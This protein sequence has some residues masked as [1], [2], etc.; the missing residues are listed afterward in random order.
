MSDP[1]IEDLLNQ[2]AELENKIIEAEET[3]DAIKNDKIDALVVSTS[4]GEKVY[5]LESAERPYR[6]FLE[7]MNEGAVT[8]SS[9]GIVLF[10]N[11]SFSDII[12]I[13]LEHILG[14]QIQKWVFSEDTEALS[15]FLEKKNDNI[16]EEIRFVR[17]NGSAI[18]LYLSLRK[19]NIDNTEPVLCVVATDLTDKKKSEEILAAEQLARSILEQAGEAIVVCD[20]SLR[21]I[22]AS[23]AAESLAGEPVLYKTFDSVFPLFKSKNNSYPLKK[24]LEKIDGSREE[25]ILIKKNSQ[26][27][28]LILNI[29]ILRGSQEETLGYVIN[30]T[31]ITSHIE[32]E[33]KL[34]QSLKEKTILLKEI[35]HRVKNNLQIISSLLRLQ[36]LYVSEDH[37]LGILNECQN[38]ITSMALIH[39]K[40]YESKSFATINIT[41]YLKELVI[42][43]CNTY[44][45]QT[46]NVKFEF[47]DKNISFPIDSA[48]PLGLILNELVTNAF[49]HAFRG[50]D[51]GE[52]MIKIM[53]ANDGN[54]NISIK[55]NGRGFPNDVDFF[56]P[57]SLGLQLVHSLIEQITGQIKLVESNGTEIIVSIPGTEN[58]PVYK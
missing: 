7:Q 13:P 54:V 24:I 41:E 52:V 25:A 58:Q 55:D 17:Q 1:N 45:M 57:S 35:H 43:L 42:F 6:I 30:L 48:V 40:L 4:G 36:S 8:L 37:L 51:Q 33:K 56:N 20:D 23:K 22:R 3:I 39:Q 50:T 14:S 16:K 18:S 5:T 12:D 34:S 49:K 53:L 21:I 32:A 9:D 38:R 19:L 31:N 44:M 28:N 29:G 2:I 10:C 47:P 15:L 46:D 11:K 27:Y 26:P